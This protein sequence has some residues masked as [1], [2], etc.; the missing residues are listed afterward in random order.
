MRN[1][2][3][4]VLRWRV[5]TA[6][7]T[8]PRG[9]FLHAAMPG[10]RF[11]SADECADYVRSTAGT[12]SRSALRVVAIYSDHTVTSDYAAVRENAA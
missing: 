9:W 12:R 6:D 2:S 7:L 10:D 1:Y 3:E 5:Y 4:T 11:A 8:Q